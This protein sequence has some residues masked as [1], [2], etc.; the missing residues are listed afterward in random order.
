LDYNIIFYTRWVS[1]FLLSVLILLIIHSVFS[2]AMKPLKGLSSAGKLIF[3]WI[4]AVSMVVSVCIAVSPHIGSGA[5]FTNIA[6]QLQQAISILTICL[7]LFVCFSIRHLGMSY[8]SYGFGISLG[9][10]VMATVSLV[11]TAWFTTNNAQ[12]LYSPLYLY[13]SLGACVALMVWTTYFA[14]P[15]PAPKM[16]LLP[17]TSP[18]FLWNSI[19]EALGD[20]PGNVAIAG[21]KPNM[22]APA[23]MAVLSRQGRARQRLRDQEAAEAGVSA[24]QANLQPA[25]NHV[26]SV[27][28]AFAMQP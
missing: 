20:D 21:F 7:L 13:S 27:R 16:V 15:E 24:A 3:R 23:E 6:G 2:Y 5:Y 26:E 25:S 14:L 17:T 11:E 1:F 19:S 10:G 28:P 8:R 18:Y 12:S 9:L 4:F 22:L